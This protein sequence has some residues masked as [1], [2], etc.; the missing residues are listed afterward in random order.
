[1]QTI[2]IIDDNDDFR[3]TLSLILLDAGYVVVDA[4]CPEE[5]FSTLKNESIDAII[6]DLNMPFCE[7][8]RSLDFLRSKEVG[9]KTILELGWVF[10]MKPVICVSA[11]TRS[12]LEEVSKELGDVPILVKP[13]SSK[14]ILQQLESSFSEKYFDVIQ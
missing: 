14:V 8:P 12:D 1:M 9:I 11:A 7:G 2:L 10:P 13:F 4:N 5:A 3:E 6:C